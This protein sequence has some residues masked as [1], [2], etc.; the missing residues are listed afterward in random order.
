[1]KQICPNLKNK[2][3]AKEFGEL[4]DLFGEEM[5]HLLW[6]RNNGYS[7]DKAPNGAESVLFGDLL[8]LAEGDRNKA[9]ILKAKVY[10]NEFFSWFG[11]WTSEDKTNVSK[12]VDENGE[13]KAVYHTV[14][15]RYDPSFKKFDTH[16]EGRET[17]IYHTDSLYMSSS[18]NGK[19]FISYEKYIIPYNDG[20]TSLQNKIRSLLNTAKEYASSEEDKYWIN[21]ALS[22]IK[23]GEFDSSSYDDRMY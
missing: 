7:I 16:I 22:K 8:E 14:A 5:A 20:K 3:V 1:M 9:L 6:S 11:D 17:A 4:Q 10:S 19:S 15:G 12:V 23:S 18:Y 13:P 21:D 2:E